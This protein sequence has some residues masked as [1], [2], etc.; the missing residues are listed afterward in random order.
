[1]RNEAQIKRKLRCYKILLNSLSSIKI[2][3]NLSLKK[4]VT[5][6]INNSLFL[7]KCY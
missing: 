3:I 7:D 2:V 6:L 1:M 5:A 4:T